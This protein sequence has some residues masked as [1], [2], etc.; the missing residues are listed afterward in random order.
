MH[1]AGQTDAFDGSQ[2]PWMSSLE[3]GNCFFAGADPVGLGL[4]PTSP[5]A[6]PR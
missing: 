2:V 4:V 1:V 6:A 3:L 5:D